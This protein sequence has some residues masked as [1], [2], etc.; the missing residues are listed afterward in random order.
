MQITAKVVL[1]WGP[2]KGLGSQAVGNLRFGS[3]TDVAPHPRVLGIISK[4]GFNG[5]GKTNVFSD[6]KRYLW[7]LSLFL[8][9]V[10][11]LC[12]A[13]YFQ[14]GGALAATLVPVVFVFV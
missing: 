3:L 10:P 9:M 6:G 5:R 8:P 12:N 11:I 13:A 7:L 14:T 2:L 4:R 1:G